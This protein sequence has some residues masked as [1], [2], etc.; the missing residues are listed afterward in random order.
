[1]AMLPEYVVDRVRATINTTGGPIGPRR[2]PDW[3]HEREGRS[4]ASLRPRQT[5]GAGNG[6][7]IARRLPVSRSTDLQ[8]RSL[9][10]CLPITVGK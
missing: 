1:M 8:L 9:M 2:L 5:A 6:R 10:S 3:L 7:L 4:A